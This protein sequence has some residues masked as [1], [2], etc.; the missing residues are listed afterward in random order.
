MGRDQSS[1]G[2]IEGG[3]RN[4]ADAHRELLADRSLQFDVEQFRPVAPKPPGWLDAVGDLV[5]TMGPIFKFLVY[6]LGGILVLAILYLIVRAI[7]AI[8]SRP[9]A[10]EEVAGKA[11]WRPSVA[12]A[13]VLLGDADALA[14]EGRFNEA[15]HLLLLR[16]VQDIRDQRPGVVRPALTSRDIAAHEAL[17]ETA[18]AAFGAIA[19]V[20]EQS[21]FGGRRVGADG[22]RTCREAYEQFA[23]DGRP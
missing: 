22:W 17:P 21:L 3:G 10:P 5:A 13:Q 11:D 1:D 7:L 16:G 4:V 19:R 2:V 14:A 12:Q 8:R 23:L 18:R 20:V 15:A 9:K 6:G